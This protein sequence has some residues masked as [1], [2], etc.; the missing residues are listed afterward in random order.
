MEHVFG[1]PEVLFRK[2]REIHLSPTRQ[3]GEKM[4]PNLLSEGGGEERKPPWGAEK[5]FKGA[6]EVLSKS[7]RHLGTW[8]GSR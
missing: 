7:S 5:G 2:L 6:G 8:W 3:K 1:Q 4:T